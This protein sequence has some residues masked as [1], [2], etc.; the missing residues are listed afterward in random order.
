MDSLSRVE[1]I[2]QSKIDGTPYEFEPQSRVEYLL[3]QLSTGGGGGGS[4]GGG[5]S[6]IEFNNL[7]NKVTSLTNRVSE[8]EDHAI[9]DNIPDD[10]Q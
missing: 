9:I 6:M 5:V 4:S 7:K 3:M 1:S 8:L 2:L 10:S